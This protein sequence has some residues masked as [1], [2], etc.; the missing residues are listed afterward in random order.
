MGAM[1]ALH[2]AEPMQRLRAG[3][4]AAATFSVG[5]AAPFNFIELDPVTKKLAAVEPT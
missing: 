5:V 1:H 3:L 2:D 4:E